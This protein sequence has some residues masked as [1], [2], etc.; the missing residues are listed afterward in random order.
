MG[1]LFS[2]AFIHRLAVHPSFLC[3]EKSPING[4]AKHPTAL[5]YAGELERV[6][7]QAETAGGSGIQPKA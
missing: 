2:S 6:V 3:Y 7:C 4:I 5:R 1:A